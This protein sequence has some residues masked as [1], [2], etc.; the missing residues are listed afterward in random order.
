MHCNMT[1][2]IASLQENR[3][4]PSGD[5]PGDTC[6]ELRPL[7][8]RILLHDALCKRTS[9]SGFDSLLLELL[10]VLVLNLELHALDPILRGQ[11]QHKQLALLAP[12]E[13]ELP[14]HA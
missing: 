5:S 7:A 10:D 9:P 6:T 4:G 13:W 2:L 8:V 12:R 14:A 1:F 3:H 11:V